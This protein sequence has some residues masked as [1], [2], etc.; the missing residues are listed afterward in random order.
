MI[1]V[2]K[3]VFV[4]SQDDA[5]YGWKKKDEWAFIH[6]CKEPFHRQ[7]V[8]Y[9]SRGCPKDNPEYLYAIRDNEI[10]LNMVDVDNPDWFDKE[11]IKIAIGFA[12]D[13]DDKKLL[14]HCNQGESRSPSIAMLYLA[15]LDKIPREDFLTAE[16]AFKKLYPA[17]NPKNGIRSH[18]RMNWMEYTSL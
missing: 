8:G 2:S 1:E 15:I 4:G 7:F 13:H 5:Y 10:A 18:L 6:C 11:M 16:R 17:Y 3:N 12:L 14:F 9:V